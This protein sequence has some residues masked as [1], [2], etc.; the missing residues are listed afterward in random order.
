MPLA[1]YL[2]IALRVFQAHKLRSGLT[3]LS[4][5]IGSFGIVVMSSLADSGLKTLQRGIEDIGGARLLSV[6][7]K[8]PEKREGKQ[9]SY[10]RGITRQDRALLAERLP[11]IEA[12]STFHSLWHRPAVN[13]QGKR[14][15]TD[16]VGADEGF[17]ALFKLR[18]SEGRFF[19]QDENRDHAK[20][21]VVG[22]ELAKKLWDDHPL[23]R[24]VI[25]QG[26]R[27]R[28][29]GV[30]SKQGALDVHFGF[31]WQDLVVLPYETL[32][33]FDPTFVQ[34]SAIMLRTDDARSNDIAK[35]VL[36]AILIERHNGVD[37]FEIFDFAGVLAKFNKTFEVMQLIVGLIAGIALFV[38][39]IGVMN[40]MLV[41]VSE[42]VRE[43]GVRKALGASPRDLLLQFL[44]EAVALSGL[45]GTI[46]V[47]SGLVTSLV[48]GWGLRRLTP[49][50]ESTISLG[51]AAVALT[52]ACGL[53]VAFGLLPARRAA[54]L[55]PVAAMRR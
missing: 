47:V 35:R 26:V 43:I 27:C 28:V 7:M 12:M 4:I 54:R 55:D 29:I 10:S 8:R 19:S 41:S 37:D 23:G 36:N 34:A 6:W 2:R 50:W 30:L 16:V 11:H 44:L 3:I 17:A 25:T 40:M 39:G 14:T 9:S 32:A 20:V 42:R 13:E 45:G 48:L 22:P 46:G 33:D 21:C 5:T 1:E 53:G 15:R 51:A 49:G 18:L 31:D 52:V 24:Q 38:G